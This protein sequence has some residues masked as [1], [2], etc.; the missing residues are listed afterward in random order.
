MVIVSPDFELSIAAC[1]ESPG[2]TIISAAD[3]IPEINDK[4]RKIP[5]KIQYFANFD[6]F[7]K[8]AFRYLY[9]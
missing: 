4:I 5:S 7:V 9:M 2:W 8:E 1:I 3:P 6:F